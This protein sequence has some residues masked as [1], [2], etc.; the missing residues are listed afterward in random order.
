MLMTLRADFMGQALSHRPLADALQDGTFILGPMNRDELRTAI[1]E[2]A[3]KQ[4][5]AF[6]PG[7][8]NRILDDVGQEPGNLPLLEFALTLMWD[9]L[10]QGWLTHAA[11]ED[12]GRVEG[13]L[14]RYA[15]KIF[16]GLSEIDQEKAKSEIEKAPMVDHVEGEAKQKE[17]ADYLQEEAFEKEWEEAVP[18][19]KVEKEDKCE[20][21]MEKSDGSKPVLKGSFCR[22]MN[23]NG[24]TNQIAGGGEDR[25]AESINPMIEAHG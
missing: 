3:E 4:G 17:S 25:D 20:Q 13:A 5:A 10:D 2:P 23:G 15:E 6:E 14:A 8:V 11:Y 12:I 18:A 16:S 21:E 22:A 1:Q 24:L 19:E 9:Q 7:L